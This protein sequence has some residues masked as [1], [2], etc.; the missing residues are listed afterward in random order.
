M[1]RQAHDLGQLSAGQVVRVTISGTEI[2]L[3]LL[4]PIN[5]SHYLKF[6]PYKYFG[7]HFKGSPARIVVPRD[8]HWYLGVD[9]GGA[10]GSANYKIAV[11]PETP[12]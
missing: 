2:N 9:F 4:D 11:L 6:K 3:V 7:G 12:R 8:G 5:K 10:S 1:K